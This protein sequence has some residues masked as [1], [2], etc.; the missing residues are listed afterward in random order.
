MQALLLITKYTIEKEV[1]TFF[2]VWA[3][4][5]IVRV[6]AHGLFMNHIGFNLHQPPSFL[7]C[8]N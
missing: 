8:A 7:V 1:A 3:M 4:V 2:Q 5:N 6:I